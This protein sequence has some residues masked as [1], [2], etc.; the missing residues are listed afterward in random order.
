[1][2]CSIAIYICIKHTLN[3]VKSVVQVAVVNNGVL[4]CGHDLLS[5]VRNFSARFSIRKF[6]KE[7]KNIPDILLQYLNLC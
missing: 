7:T 1:M 6:G 2:P 4:L 3:T 5:F